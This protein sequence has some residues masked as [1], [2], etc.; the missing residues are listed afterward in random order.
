MSS[1]QP[2]NSIS[3]AQN[4]N[5]S[6]KDSAKKYDDIMRVIEPTAREPPPRP[7]STFRLEIESDNKDKKDY[8]KEITKL[9]DS[10]SLVK[11]VP[12]QTAKPPAATINSDL[13]R[14]ILSSINEAGSLLRGQPKNELQTK[15]SPTIPNSHLKPIAPKLPKNLI[16]KSDSN[17]SNTTETSSGQSSAKGIS[18]SKTF[19]QHVKDMLTERKKSVPDSPP[20]SHRPPNTMEQSLNELRAAFSSLEL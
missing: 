2:S 3:V 19:T 20:Q 14:T 15:P 11:P 9:I 5:L 17:G 10:M 16:E 13:N 6:N 1:S 8:E 12:M 7:I 4:N 18:R